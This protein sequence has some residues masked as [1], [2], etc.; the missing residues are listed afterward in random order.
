M[1]GR[2]WSSDVCSSDLERF[3]WTHDYG[4]IWEWKLTFKLKI[5]ISFLEYPIAALAIAL[6][7]PINCPRALS[8]SCPTI[9]HMCIITT[10]LAACLVARWSVCT[11]KRKWQQHSLIASAKV[12]RPC[13]SCHSPVDISAWAT[14]GHVQE[15]ARVKCG[16]VCTHVRECALKTIGWWKKPAIL[17]N[18]II[19]VSPAY[20]L[21]LDFASEPNKICVHETINYTIGTS[22]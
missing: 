22:Q 13:A 7:P 12:K 11:T 4:K 10:Q 8:S 3:L 14:C 1:C 20:G 2:D 17:Y 16:S 21:L 19:T 9:A 15:C 6:T 18:G 5:I